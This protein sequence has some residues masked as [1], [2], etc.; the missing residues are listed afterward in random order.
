MKP[1]L[2]LV[3]ITLA[4]I[5][6][7]QTI[8]GTWKGELN[9]QGSKLPLVL[10]IKK[11]ESGYTSV[12]NSPQQSQQDIPADKTTFSN[13]ELNF[14]IKILN[15]SY[16][17]V[18]KT[19]HFEG[20]F[21]QNGMT[22]PLHFSKSSNSNDTAVNQEIPYLNNKA[23]DNK[24]I[25]NFLEYLAQKNQGIGSV[26]IFRDG[27][28]VYNKSFGQDQLKNISYDATTQ[29]Q[30]GSISKLVTAVMLFQLIENKKL[31]LTDKLSKFYPDIPNASKITIENMLNH[32]SG[33]GDY[34]GKSLENNWLF[35][36]PVGNEAIIAEIKK[37][38]VSFQPGEKTQYSNSAYFLL[39]RILEKIQN[40]PYNVILKENILDKA[41]MTH[42]FSVLDDPKNIF[43]SYQ[44]IGSW[45][46]VKDFDFHNCIGLGDIVS[47][48]KDLNIFMNALFN[49]RFIKKETL[50]VM[51]PKNNENFFGRGMMKIPF[52][53]ISSYGHAGDTAGSHSLAAYE[54]IDKLSLAVTV[55]GENF[56]HNDLYI[57]IL[58]I[59][60]GQEFEYPV[61]NTQKAPVSELK[62]YI[63]DYASKDIP[64]GLKIFVKKDALFAQGTGQPEFPLEYVAK[65]QFKFAAAGVQITFLPEKQQIQFLQGGKTYLF[66]KK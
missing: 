59:V 29:Y 45:N 3:L 38:G 8:E 34:V 30:I 62:Q 20:N 17:G 43:K 1:K 12:M 44:Y 24:K 21:V 6:Y 53:N 61:F 28:E 19:D 60:Y 41:G 5:F 42:T 13:N 55:N 32:T 39:S 51:M 63:G 31:N 27:V 46:E 22:L 64:L 54:P 9:I 23:I 10:T 11:N 56:P 18:Y 26:S 14:E 25:D 65:D 15:A 47:T 16:K 57:A 36:K 4:Q 66:N 37:Q 35:G 50:E 49:N 33:L 58:K 7:A 40:K 2:L 52:Y 48:T